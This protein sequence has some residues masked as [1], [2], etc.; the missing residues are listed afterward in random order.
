MATE[1]WV[2]FDVAAGFGEMRWSSLPVGDDAWAAF[3]PNL[4]VGA[5]SQYAPHT[6]L[7][8]GRD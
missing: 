1:L 2:E 8:Q 6:A 5:G 3:L 4:H 7:M